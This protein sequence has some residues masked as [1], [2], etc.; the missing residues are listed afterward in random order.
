MEGSR[1]FLSKYPRRKYTATKTPIEKLEHLSKLLG[2]PNIYIKRDDLLGLTAGGNKTRKLEFIMADVLEKGADTII[3]CGSLQS[4]HC[5]LTLAAAVK[6]GLECHLILEETSFGNYDAEA[7]GNN[8]LYKLLGANIHV[9]E[10]GANMN[11]EMLKLSE[12]LEDRG[13]KTYIV[14]LGGSNELGTLGYTA[15]AQEIIEQSFDTGV[16]FDH[17]VTANGSGATCAGLALGFFGRQ[18]NINI[19]AIGVMG[20]PS[21][22]SALV[23]DLVDRTA[24]FLDISVDI[25]RENLRFYGEYV[26]EGY[27]VPTKAMVEAVQM[28]ARTEGILLDPVYTGKVMSGLIDL[29]RNGTFKKCENV[30]FLHSGGSPALYANMDVFEENVFTIGENV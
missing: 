1:M 23:Y 19:S 28:L 5:R 17:L 10:N 8:F 9:V 6:E 4:N 25:P 3:T 18:A 12:T 27:A 11:E 30:L 29:V 22:Q 15:C 20:D 24:E 7:S 2:G 21:N 14:P 26:G 13:H 16:T